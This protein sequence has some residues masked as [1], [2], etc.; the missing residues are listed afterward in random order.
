MSEL[1][2]SSCSLFGPGA[3]AK[4]GELLQP[5]LKLSLSKLHLAHCPI[6]DAGKG[7]VYGDVLFITKISGG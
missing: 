3:A 6:K 5:R 7:Q 4:L 1:D 2:L